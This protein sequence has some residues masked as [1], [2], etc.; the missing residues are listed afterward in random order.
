[1]TRAVAARRLRDRDGRAVVIG[2]LVSAT[3]LTLVVLPTVD[4]AV[5]G[6]HPPI[7]RSRPTSGIRARSAAA[8]GERSEN[9]TKYPQSVC[10]YAIL[11]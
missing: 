5:A 7:D 8:R 1:M 9:A 3:P 2:G 10:G 4:P 6:L 11:C